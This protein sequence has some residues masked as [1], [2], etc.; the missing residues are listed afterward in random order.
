MT[1]NRRPI[2][3]RPD[4]LHERETLCA[5]FDGELQ[6]D[7]AR[8]ALKRLGHDVQWRD[9]VGRWQLYGDA[10]RGQ[11]Q[12]VAAG[13]FADRV[14]LALREEQAQVVA[15][16]ARA[17]GGRRAWMGGALAASVAVAALFV[18]RPFSSDAPPSN[19]RVSPDVASVPAAA[20][21]VAAAV[22]SRAPAAAASGA[23]VLSGSTNNPSPGSALG[24]SA[25]AAAVAAVE[26]PRRAGE[27][28]AARNQNPRS[29][30]RAGRSTE[31][32]AVAAAAIAQTA[33]ADASLPGPAATPHKPFQPEHVEPA[34]RPWPRAV[35]PQYSGNGALTASF[36]TSSANSPSFYP[37][38]P[39]AAMPVVEETPAQRDT[40]N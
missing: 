31:Q 1:S 10:L 4:Q 16:P 7:E 34:S 27:R 40:Q 29:I 24:A 32:S 26:V 6:G 20:P 8:F 12:G 14:A 36:G 3:D 17:S 33:I 38:E 15:I 18:T 19:N 25:A 11:A 30:D 13:G 22:A 35:L 5:L 9:T 23:S 39:Q 37:F 28:R 21:R 2:D